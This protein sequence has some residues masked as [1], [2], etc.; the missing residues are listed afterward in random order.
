M[1][2]TYAQ[3][4]AKVLARADMV[5]T[6][7][8]DSTQLLEIINASYAKLYRRII[9]VFEDYFSASTTIA[10][11]SG[12]DT[13]SLSAVSPKVRKLRGVD[14][15]LS[16]AAGDFVSLKP[17]NW[18]ERDQYASGAAHAWARPQ[19]GYRYCLRG[20]NLVIAPVPSVTNSLKVYYVP[21]LTKLTADG[22]SILEE[23][24]EG[25]EEYIA[26]D[27]AITLL[28]ME[29]SDTRELVAEREDIWKDIE[30]DAANRDADQ[31]RTMVSSRRDAEDEEYWS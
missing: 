22:D 4:K 6:T 21:E 15:I 9:N 1:A 17:F 30:A 5:G 11:V 16:N 2:A 20:T 13:Y 29:E 7:F 3:L 25:W 31:P 23:I 18:S 10:L 27:A 19:S 12:T 14:L 26:L 8:R 28:R 24:K